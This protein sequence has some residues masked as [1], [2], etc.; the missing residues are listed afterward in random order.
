MNNLGRRLTFIIFLALFSLYIALPTS[1]SLDFSMAGRQIKADIDIPKISLNLFGKNFSSDLPLKQGLDLQGGMQVI[2]LA[3]MN[4]IDLPDREDALT[5]AQEII[6]RR[7]DLY[8]VSEPLIQTA[9]SGDQ[10]RLIIELPGVDDPAQALALVGTTAQLDFRVETELPALDENGEQTDTQIGFLPT[11]LTGKELKKAATQFDPNTGEPVISLQFDDKGTE[12]FAAMTTDYVGKRIGIFIDGYPV[13]AP[14]V[15]TPIL[16]GQAIMTGNF[17]VDDA[18]QLAIQLNAGALPVPIQILEQRTI[19]AN[20]GEASVK[21]SVFAGLVGLG[22]VVVFMILNYGFHGAVA[23]LALAIYAALTVAI[24]KIMGVTL[25]LPG[26]AGLL[27]SIGMAVDA[28]ILIF[29]R[30]KEEFRVGHSYLNALELGFGRAWE[31]IKDANLVTIVTALV[32]IN[33]LNLEFLNRS[34]MVRGFGVTLLIGVLLSLFTGVVVS[35]T[36]LRAFA[37]ILQKFYH[38]KDQS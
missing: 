36:L 19:G 12:L 17:T 5:S 2:L 7:V 35:R 16:T 13:V 4:G 37:P 14:V 24:Y 20:L 31:S 29:E 27:L 15:S 30:F 28:N 32:L 6:R 3:D 22:L 18:K 34:G 10:Y 9:K 33:P 1:I 38:Q 8:G 26:I 23:A 25:T 21:Q 11:E